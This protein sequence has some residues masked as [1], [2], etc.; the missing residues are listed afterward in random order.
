MPSHAIDVNSSISDPASPAIGDFWFN[1]TDSTLNSWNG[2]TWVNVAFSTLPITP[3]TGTL[4]F[5]TT[6]QEL[7]EWNGTTW[8]TSTPIAITTLND[9]KGCASE[10]NIII[11]STTLGCEGDVRIGN[12]NVRSGLTT[13]VEVSFTFEGD[14]FDSLSATATLKTPVAGTDGLSGI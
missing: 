6:D 4:W 3:S 11:T 12:A 14:L 10:G 13:F 5:D 8:I 2:T 1:L 9:E 7:M